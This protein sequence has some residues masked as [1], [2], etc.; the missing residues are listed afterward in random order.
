MGSRMRLDIEGRRAEEANAGFLWTV[1]LS[2]R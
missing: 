2:P 1:V